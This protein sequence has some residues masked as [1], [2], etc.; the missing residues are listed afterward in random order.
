MG[1]E[2]YITEYKHYNASCLI[3]YVFRN[4]FRNYYSNEK[5]G[6]C[7]VYMHGKRQSTGF[8]VKIELVRG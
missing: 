4:F 1:L 3:Y 6:F 8:Q 5:F 2:Y 7:L